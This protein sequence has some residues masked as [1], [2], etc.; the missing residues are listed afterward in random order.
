MYDFRQM[1]AREKERAEVAALC[2]TLRK[3]EKKLNHCI[4]FHDGYYRIYQ[5]P[6]VIFGGVMIFIFALIALSVSK[7]FGILMFAL[8]ILVWGILG[9]NIWLTKRLER[10]RRQL[11]E[12]IYEIK[13]RIEKLNKN[14]QDEQEVGEGNE[15]TSN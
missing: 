3:K 5:I 9:F 4:V 8:D 12:E 2:E 6:R 7:L 10:Q 1:E 14:T 13:K 11:E 15:A